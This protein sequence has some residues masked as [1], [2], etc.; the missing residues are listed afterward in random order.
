MLVFV[1]IA[2]NERCEIVHMPCMHACR[3]EV[4]AV[5]N[6]TSSGVK[7]VVTSLLSRLIDSEYPSFYLGGSN[8][9]MV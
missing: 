8:S 4:T 1:V 9:I 7:R 6:L 5:E 2:K 3:A